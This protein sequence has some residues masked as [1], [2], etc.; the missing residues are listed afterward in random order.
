MMISQAVAL[1]VQL[2]RQRC[3]SKKERLVTYNKKSLHSC[4]KSK[5][6][7]LSNMFITLEFFSLGQHYGSLYWLP[8][9]RTH[10]YCNWAEQHAVQLQQESNDSKVK[11]LTQVSLKYGWLYLSI[12]ASEIILKC[13]QL[14]C[15]KMFIEVILTVTVYV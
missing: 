5:I 3:T 14:F 7:V 8:G 1:S 11:I 4:A 9:W 12:S 15:D 10:A 2:G 13:L 6:G